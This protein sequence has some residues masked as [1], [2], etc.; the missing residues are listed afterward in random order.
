MWIVCATNPQPTYA[1]RT[2]A[3]GLVSTSLNAHL[4]VAWASRPEYS[5]GPAGRAGARSGRPGHSLP[6]PATTAVSPRSQLVH[7]NGVAAQLHPRDARPAATIA[8]DRR[9][10]GAPPRMIE[11][12]DGL[13]GDADRY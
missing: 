8:L 10:A 7:R 9:L 13:P 4:N 3:G 1:K 6:R 11:H 5:R 2:G 12:V